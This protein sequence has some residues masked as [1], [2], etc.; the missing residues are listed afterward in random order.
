LV[1]ASLGTLDGPGASIAVQQDGK[2]LYS[3]G[4]GHADLEHDAHNSP[5]TVFHIA[6][7]SKQFTAFSIAM[8]AD[9]GK[10]SLQD[11]IR[12]YLPEMYDFGTPITINHLIHH[13]SGLRDQWNL[14]M[15]AGWRL[16]DVI[17]RKQ[18]MRLISKQ[19]ELNFK[20][21]DEYV[22]CNG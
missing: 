5:T 10:L 17:T 14:L 13:T 20:P 21:G 6:S 11:D 18:I 7:V 1:R 16:D 8:L 12:K 4:F 9:Q 22:Y 19:R 3:G 15:L 2:I